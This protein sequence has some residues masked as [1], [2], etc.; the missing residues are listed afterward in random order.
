MPVIVVGADTELG[1]S[2]LDALL[3]REGEV[4]AFVT[5]PDVGATLKDRSVKVAIGD[6]SDGSHIGGAALN[7][8]C[9]VLIPDAAADE[10]E[11]SFAQTPEAVVSAWAEGL[12][13]ASVTRAI[14]IED[15]TVPGGA[16]VIRQA[17]SQFASVSAANRSAHEVASEVAALED[18]ATV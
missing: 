10:R 5:S 2:V 3:P 1:A 6:V 11:R 17:V 8:F 14:W 4:R 7:A 12:E 18:A 15:G 9:A 13:D 16:D